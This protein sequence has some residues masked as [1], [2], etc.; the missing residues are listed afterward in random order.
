MSDE[1]CKQCLSDIGDV[2]Q[3]V[4]NLQGTV[5]TLVSALN[6]ST[7]KTVMAMIG[8]IA[9]SIGS[10]Y[11]GTPW[12]IEIAMWFTMSGSLFVFLVTLWKR[13]CLGFWEKS[14]RFTFC[15]YGAYVSILRI[16]HYQV[17]TPLTQTEGMFANMLLTCLAVGFIVQSWRSTGR[18]RYND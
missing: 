13:K 2:K 10:K 1:D 6:D 11:I 9:A 7:K 16:Y 14:I 17:N 15:G 5:D 3:I 4:G 12:Y 8:L 18:R